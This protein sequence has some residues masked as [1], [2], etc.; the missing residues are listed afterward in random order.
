MTTNVNHSGAPEPTPLSDSKAALAAKPGQAGIDPRG[1]R[2]GAGITAVLLLAVIGLGLDAA[3]SLPALIADRASQPAFILFSV[4]AALF[5]WGAFAGIQRHP[6]GLFFKAVIRPRLARRA[7]SKTRARPRSRRVSDSSSPS[8]ASCCISRPCPTP[9]SSLRAWRSSP[10]SSTRC[11]T[12]A[13]DASSTCCSFELA[14]LVDLD[15]NRELT[16]RLLA[17]LNK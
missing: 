9:S 12:T 6:Y 7:T 17:R 3:A 15:P 16:E 8:S 1:P 14:S 2:F 10:H 4:I 5:A 11:S 13:S